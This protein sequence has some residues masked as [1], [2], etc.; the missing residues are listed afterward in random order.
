MTYLESFRSIKESSVLDTYQDSKGAHIEKRV[1]IDLLD[2][3]EQR[4][5]KH[6]FS[7]NQKSFV[8]SFFIQ[9]LNPQKI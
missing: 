5:G 4:Q 7:L 1:R 2:L 3:K 6:T 9:I 8:K